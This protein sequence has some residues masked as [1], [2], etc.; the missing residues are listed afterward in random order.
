MQLRSVR[1]EIGYSDPGNLQISGLMISPSVIGLRE[2]RMSMC[3]YA[4]SPPYFG[5]CRAEL[6]ADKQKKHTLK[7]ELVSFSGM[8]RENCGLIYFKV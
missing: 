7:Y 4:F 3:R 6:L 2:M 5:D 8:Y 1:C